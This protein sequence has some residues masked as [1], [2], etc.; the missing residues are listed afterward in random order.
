MIAKRNLGL[1]LILFGIIFFLNSYSG[2]TGFVVGGQVAESFGSWVGIVFIIAGGYLF[3]IRRKTKS[4]IEELAK[5]H[6][7]STDEE[8]L[9]QLQ[10]KDRKLYNSREQQL[11]ELEDTLGGMKDI[12]VSP[13]R[14][15]YATYVHLTDKKRAK[16]IIANGLYRSGPNSYGQTFIFTGKDSNQKAR[17][18]VFSLSRKG[19]HAGVQATNAIL[20]KT[21]AVP[22]MNQFS[23][24]IPNYS[25]TW[26]ALFPYDLPRSLMRDVEDIRIPI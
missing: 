19:K 22:K 1:T 4:E 7:P 26:K 2:I 9:A 3:T 14:K 8:I 23:G 10:P 5:E 25:S 16:S 17:K 18:F 15:G 11:E 6:I 24:R 20:F 21:D 13:I 12:Y